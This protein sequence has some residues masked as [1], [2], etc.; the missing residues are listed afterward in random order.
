MQ[1]IVQN[2]CVQISNMKE[3]IQNVGHWRQAGMN[4]AMKGPGS[5]SAAI[6]CFCCFFFPRENKKNT[7]FSGGFCGMGGSSQESP[8]IVFFFVLFVFPRE[9]QKQKKHNV[10]E[11]LGNG[12]VQPRVSK[13]CFVFSNVFWVLVSQALFF[14]FF[15][16]L[17]ILDIY[18]I[19]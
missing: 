17:V 11:V 14:H 9:N 6:P 13:Y 19:I 8:N 16:V 1:K 12:R 10:P 5:L 18:N 3:N 2:A 15:G 4:V 7:H